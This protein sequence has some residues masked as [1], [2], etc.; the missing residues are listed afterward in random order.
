MRTLPT[1][2]TTC[3]F[4]VAITAFLALECGPPS[5]SES[6]SG[7]AQAIY[8]GQWETAYPAV[9]CVVYE[10]NGRCCTGTLIAPNLVLT[11]KHCLQSHTFN[12]GNDPFTFVSHQVDGWFPFFPSDTDL[13]HDVQILRLANPIYDIRP[14]PINTLPLPSVG[15]NCV[16]VGYGSTTDGTMNSRHSAT[17]QVSQVGPYQSAIPGFITFLTGLASGVQVVAG[18]AGSQPPPGILADGDSGGP[19]LCNG[20]VTGVA[21]G[22]D[23][24]SPSQDWYTAVDTQCPAGMSI[25]DSAHCPLSAS[26]ITNVASDYV[27]EPLVSAITGGPN[28]RDLFIRGADGQVLHKWSN[29]SQWGPSEFGWQPLGGYITGTPEAVTWGGNRIDVFVRGGDSNPATDTLANDTPWHL[30][31]DGS[32]WSW[33]PLGSL[34]LVGHPSAVAW[35]PNRLAVFGVSTDQ[36]V[37]YQWFDGTNWNDWQSPFGNTDDHGNTVS[38]S[39]SVKAIPAGGNLVDVFAVGTNGALYESWV[40]FDPQVGP[41]TSGAWSYMNGSI[42][43]APSVVSWG[44]GRIDVFV[45]SG[46]HAVYHKAFDPSIPPSYDG[47]SWHPSLGGSDWEQLGGSMFASPAAASYA[48]GKLTLLAPGNGTDGLDYKAWFGV[49]WVPSQTNWIALGGIPVGTPALL[50]APNTN[51]V[52]AYTV[53]RDFSIGQMEYSTTALPGTYYGWGGIG[54]LGGT[55]S[56]W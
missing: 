44:S 21:F 31:W 40:E 50:S 3:L 14:L 16:A 29:G 2:R 12:T 7:A 32:Q 1:T 23:S 24:K 26:W 52:D 10:P 49:S 55:A 30:W 41:L 45:K 33:E 56:P 13:T 5:Q 38:F 43:G 20:V 48:P 46:D 15:T 6:S 54:P 27:N 47:T 35:A 42:W 36:N 37:Y 11:A 9:G 4:T 39:G 8:G 25:F 51:I 28:V 17:V 22:V 18:P 19:L 34:V 53:G